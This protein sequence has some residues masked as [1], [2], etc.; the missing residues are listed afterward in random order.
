MTIDPLAGAQTT[1]TG[2]AGESGTPPKKDSPEQI[3]KAAQDFEAL[4][5]ARMLQ[6]IRESALSGLSDEPDNAGAVALEM[7]E[8]QMAQVMAA[9]GGLGL[10][11][12]IASGLEPPRRLPAAAE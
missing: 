2:P 10:S 4:L 7:A 3:R 8:Q 6:S 5:L 12:L 11:R 1:I 9:N